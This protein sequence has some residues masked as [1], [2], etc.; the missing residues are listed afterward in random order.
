MGWGGSRPL[1]INIFFVFLKR[2][3][4]F[5]EIICTNSFITLTASENRFTAGARLRGSKG[6]QLNTHYFLQQNLCID[7]HIIYLHRNIIKT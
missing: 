4:C 5:L 6:I 7:I 2:V 1:Q 3:L